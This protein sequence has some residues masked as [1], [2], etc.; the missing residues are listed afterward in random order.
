M[1]KYIR[2]FIKHYNIGEQDIILCQVC[3]SSIGINIHHI[4]YKSQG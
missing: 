4:T 3:G 1:K 2:N